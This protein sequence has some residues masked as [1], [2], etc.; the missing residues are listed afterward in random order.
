MN[1]SLLKGQQPRMTIATHL[2][3]VVVPDSTTVPPGTVV[4]TPFGSLLPFASGNV[5]YYISPAVS[6]RA[7]FLARVHQTVEFVLRAASEGRSHTAQVIGPCRLAGHYDHQTGNFAVVDTA[8]LASLGGDV[9]APEGN[10]SAHS[11]TFESIEQVVRAITPSAIPAVMYDIGLRLAEYKR[12]HVELV[13][14]TAA[15]GLA[16]P[17]LQLPKPL[18]RYD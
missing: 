16:R 11:F 14:A 13:E 12:R 5:D 3:H 15:S 17:S 9:G 18:I 1:T 4:V 7:P 8:A 10:R 2:F 6:A